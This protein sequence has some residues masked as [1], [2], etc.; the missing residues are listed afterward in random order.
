MET[1]P[2]KVLVSLI[3]QKRFKQ[4]ASYISPLIKTHKN[5]VQ[6][7]HL[8]SVILHGLNQFKQCEH[9]LLTALKI[10]ADFCP[11]ITNLALLKKQQGQ[12]AAACAL[13]E[14]LVKLTPNDASALLNLGVV[15]NKS[16]QYSAATKVLKQ[17]LLNGHDN[18]NIKIALGQAYLSQEQLD[19]AH[20]LFSQVLQQA[21]HNIAALNNIGLVYKAQCQFEQAIAVYKQA[22]VHSGNSTEILKNLAS[23]YTLIG[24]LANSRRLYQQMLHSDPLDLD[25]H[26]WLNQMLWEHKAPDFLNS[27]HLALKTN[28]DA[29]QL[30]LALAHKLRQ[31]GSVSDAQDILESVLKA[32][33]SYVAC[34]LEL[35]DIYREQGKFERSLECLT[36][37]NKCE[38]SNLVVKQELAKS[39][40][41]VNEAKKALS[42]LNKLLKVAP[43]HQGYWAYKTV[44]LRLQNSAE[45]DYLCDYDKFIL[46]AFINVPKGYSDLTAFNQELSDELKSIHYGTRHPLDQTLISGSQTSEKLFDY[47][48]PIIK[49]IKHSLHE[50]T[51]EFLAQL[52][53]DANHPML[54]R[55]TLNFIETDSWSVI[56]NNSG[57]HKNHYHPAGWYS[58]C[59]YVNVPNEVKNTNTH[60]GWINFGQPGFNMQSKLQAE[61]SIAPEEGLIVQFPSYFWHGTNPFSSV[62]KRITTPYDILPV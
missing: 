55:N 1:N 37:A 51:K 35:A 2:S 54:S 32:N 6:L 11:A 61:I 26:H 8:Y 29:P 49:Q 24:D 27:Y 56:L 14:K 20:S 25:S 28:K 59:Y 7:W 34:S 53:K 41:S 40:I 12:F 57:F 45:Y 4:A 42:L 31:S 47:Q 36:L 19:K 50:Q 9:A 44:A 52:P 48:L 21:P 3:Q 15:Y 13:Y 5:N 39:F 43:H 46:K 23:C 10:N 18:I 38:S 62:E 30:Q 58:S 17:A 16:K 60:Q 22:L 33:K